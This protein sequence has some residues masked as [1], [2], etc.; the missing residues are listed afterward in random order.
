MKRA[1]TL[2]IGTSEFAVP[3]LKELSETDFV[4]LTGI[5]TQPDKAVGR[6]H[7]IMQVS[8]VK[9]W[10]IENAVGVEISQPEKL[11][12]AQQKILQKIDPELIIVA[13][14]GQM[15]PKDMIEF[16]KY[17]CLN[18]H[19]SLLPDLRGAV[20]MPMAILK[21]YK[22][23]G[24]SI[25]IMTEKLD[26]GDIIA[27]A[28]VGI[29]E[30]ETTE[31]LTAKASKVG[32]DLLVRIL[33]DWI[34]GKIEPTAQDDLKA[35]YCYTGDIAKD[36]AEIT[37]ETDVVTAERMI[38]AFNPWPVAWAYIDHKGAQKRLKIFKAKILA[39]DQKSESKNLQIRRDGKRLFLDLENGSL[40]L[41]EIQLE[42]K[43]RSNAKD[44]LFLSLLLED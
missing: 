16:P 40:E 23:T 8:P 4:D 5:V 27:Q 14:Y 39:A 2:F 11:K 37:Y 20:P 41:L 13:S 24:V 21:G 25:P 26:E 15:I 33:P 10:V 43:E 30:N 31:S 42:G 9:K 17:K 36:K 38:R 44:Y 29:S 35:T 19:V 32:A 22:Q 12:N 3:I 28:K 7:S 34:S 18:V 1:R 6:H